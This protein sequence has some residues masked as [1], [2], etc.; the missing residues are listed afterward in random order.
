MKMTELERVEEKLKKAELEEQ[1]A[2][3]KKKQ[4]KKEIN[5]IKKKQETQRKIKKAEVLERFEKNITGKQ[6]ETS[7]E[8]IE[9]FIEYVFYKE[10]YKEKLNEFTEEYLNED[11]E[12]V[13]YEGMN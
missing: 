13:T 11:E 8:E 3:N 9:K 1:Q 10:V 6:K 12:E 5:A 2:K 7:G 4:I